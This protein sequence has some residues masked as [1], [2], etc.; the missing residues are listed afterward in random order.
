MDPRLRDDVKIGTVV[1]IAMTKNIPVNNYI[2]D[3]VAEI[4]SEEPFA[5][6][7]IE[8]RT[9]KEYIGF[10]KEIVYP[11]PRMTS[12][13]L[14]RLISTHET[15]TFEMKSTFM[16]DIK[17]SHARNQAIRNEALVREVVEAVA[18]FMNTSGGILCIGITD[19]RE[20]L[21]LES[22][23][24]LLD[25][26]EEKSDIFRSKINESL[27]KYMQDKII[28]SLIEIEI[29]QFKNKEICLIH[30]QTSPEPILINLQ[31]QYK[32]DNKDKSGTFCLCYIRTNNGTQKITIKEFMTHWNIKR[33]LTQ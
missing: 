20:V 25:E 7:G 32:L 12:F 15:R 19:K 3:R 2:E 26:N 29:M 27:S 4:I 6:D 8:V 17:Q 14:E 16:Y 22:D 9:Q 11:T 21:G 13:E 10:V 33:K 18:A 30:V 28:H 24:S 5:E 23:Y 31:I 1:K